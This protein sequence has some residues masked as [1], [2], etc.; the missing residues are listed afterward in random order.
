MPNISIGIAP[1]ILLFGRPLKTRLPAP[2]NLLQKDDADFEVRERDKEQ[3]LKY[4][5]YTDKTRRAKVVEINPGD[6]V[7]VKQ[8]RLSLHPPWDPRP[9]TI[10]KVKGT[11]VFLEQDGKPKVRSKNKSKLVKI[12]KRGV[13]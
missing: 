6:T 13:R 5:Q 11:K 10:T 7:V 9:F 3:K 4:K 8:D 12:P 2:P 1:S